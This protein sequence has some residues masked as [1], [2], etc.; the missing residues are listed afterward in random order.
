[1]GTPNSFGE[2]GL[3]IVGLGVEYPPHELKH[4]CLDILVDRF[5]SETPA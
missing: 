1:M 5:Y 3:S 4:D 2:L